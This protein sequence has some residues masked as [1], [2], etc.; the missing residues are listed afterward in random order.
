[1]NTRQTIGK[2][3]VF[4]IENKKTEENPM[5]I[6]KNVF[7]FFKLELPFC[8]PPTSIHRIHLSE[9][10][11]LFS[12]LAAPLKDC[13]TIGFR[14]ALVILVVSVF[15]FQGPS[16]WRGIRW[17]RSKRFRPQTTRPLVHRK[18][19]KKGRFLETPGT[20]RGV[21][22]YSKTRRR[23]WNFSGNF[24]GSLHWVTRIR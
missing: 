7:F 8:W 9:M 20:S 13:A 18:R 12:F 5:K 3:F 2:T 10:F 4:R 16:Y 15:F 1:M 17:N 6:G 21:A 22:E 23:F 19:K 14:L 24:W 11:D